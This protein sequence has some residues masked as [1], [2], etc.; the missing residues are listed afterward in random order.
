MRNELIGLGLNSNWIGRTIQ[1]AQLEQPY[2]GKRQDDK[3]RDVYASVYFH[4]G[5]GESKS[6]RSKTR[7]VSLMTS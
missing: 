1:R 4:S 6:G 2:G 3:G 7:V 5:G